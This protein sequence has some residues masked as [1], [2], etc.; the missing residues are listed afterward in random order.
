MLRVRQKV[1]N[2]LSEKDRH[3]ERGEQRLADRKKSQ[4]R[5]GFVCTRVSC[6]STFGLPKDGQSIERKDK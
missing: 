2:D 3:T 4:N 6:S 1:G 5:F